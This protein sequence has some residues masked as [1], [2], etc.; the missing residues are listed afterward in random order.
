MS[1]A[2]VATEGSA[3]AQVLSATQDRVGV[4]VC[5]SGLDLGTCGQKNWPYCLLRWVRAWTVLESLPG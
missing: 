1:M 2:P 4:R 3:D 5:V